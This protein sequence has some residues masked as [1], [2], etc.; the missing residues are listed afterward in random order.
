MTAYRIPEVHLWRVDP[1]LRNSD[2]DQGFYRPFLATYSGDEA[3]HPTTPGCNSV[4][5]DI[6]H[7][8]ECLDHSPTCLLHPS[9][10]TPIC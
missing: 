5:S 3:P 4:S 6:E 1:N 7:L 8:L 2:V 9:I 10:H